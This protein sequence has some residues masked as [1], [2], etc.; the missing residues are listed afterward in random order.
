MENDIKN[1][2]GCRKHFTQAMSI[3]MFA[4]FGRHKVR[5][6]MNNNIKTIHFNFITLAVENA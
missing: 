2:V 3:F 1:Q 4:A 5:Q 6:F